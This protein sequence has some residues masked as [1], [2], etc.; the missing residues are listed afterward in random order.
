MDLPG[1]SVE[2]EEL[3]CEALR[4]AAW[5]IAV[6][7]GLGLLKL[8]GGAFGH[9][10]ALLTDALHSLVDAAVSGTLLGALV[11]AQRPADKEHPYGHTRVE[12]VAGAGAGLLLILLALGVGW[13]ALSSVGEH[14]EEPEPFTLLIA[15]AGVV[16]QEGLYRYTNRVARTANS[17]ALRA[18]AWDYRLDALG[19]AVVLSGVAAAR[20]GGPDWHW[21][22]HAAAVAVAV[23]VLWVAG[24]LLVDNVNELMDRQADGELLQTVRTEALAVS[25]VRGVEKLRIRK[26]GLEHL[27]DIHVEVDPDQSV[28]EGH[29]IAHAVK[30]RLIGRITTIRDVLVHIEP[31]PRV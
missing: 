10:F 23:A 20:W 17:T 8:L 19:S 3:Y 25:G 18:S 5:G 27:V 4:A 30:D 29:A 7:L 2:I 31:D 9:S 16:I 22:D 15:A 1:L 6:S 11:L 26:T 12:T 14:R 24:R 13:R 21:A 28:R